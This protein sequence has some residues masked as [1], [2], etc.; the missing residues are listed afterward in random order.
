MLAIELSVSVV[1]LLFIVSAMA[2][3]GAWFIF[4]W[5]IKD[6]Q[7]EDIED[8]AERLTDLDAHDAYQVKPGSPGAKP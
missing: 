1:V 3:V 5:A 2:G 6:K 8:V 4:V 7:F